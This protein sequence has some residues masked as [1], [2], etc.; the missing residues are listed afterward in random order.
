MTHD[1]HAPFSQVSAFDARIEE[2]VGGMRVV[3]AGGAC[4]RLHAAQFGEAG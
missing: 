1:F 4:Q 3:Q 2:N